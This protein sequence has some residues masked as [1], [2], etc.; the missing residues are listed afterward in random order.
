MRINC[1]CY[2]VICFC[3]CALLYATMK[4]A[5]E[6]VAFW[7]RVSRETICKLRVLSSCKMNG[8]PCTI[9]TPL[10]KRHPNRA[11]LLAFIAVFVLRCFTFSAF[12]AY[13]SY[14][15][16]PRTFSLP[17]PPRFATPCAFLP[18]AASSLPRPLGTFSTYLHF[19]DYSLHFFAS[20]PR[21]YN[22]NNS[23]VNVWWRVIRGVYLCSSYLKSFS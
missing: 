18:L 2:I 7:C 15:L 1:Y 13:P 5:V 6:L 14:F 17:V 4:R 23:C 21:F 10:P 9:T 16:L 8:L 19:L 12:L 22:L 3:F 11:S 20:P